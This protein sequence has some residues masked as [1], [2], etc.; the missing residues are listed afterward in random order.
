M[1]QDNRDQLML[2]AAGRKRRQRCSASACWLL[3][4]VAASCG[5][6]SSSDSSTAIADPEVSA[7]IQE[8]CP[9]ACALYDACSDDDTTVCYQNCDNL[10]A[11]FGD[12]TQACLI[13]V[14]AMY[15]C[16][17][18]TDCEPFKMPNDVCVDEI[19]VVSET[20]FGDPDFETH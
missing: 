14:R 15:Q 12:D 11:D 6:D 17:L 8:L 13:A 7:E 3:L 16:Y 19:Q 18:D 4:L 20:C 10:E 5:G 1:K 2:A 9:M